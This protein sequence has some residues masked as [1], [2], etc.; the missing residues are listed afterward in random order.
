MVP[1]RSVCC[2]TS[3]FLTSAVPGIDLSVSNHLTPIGA[4]QSHGGTHSRQCV[5]TLNLYTASL[6]REHFAQESGSIRSPYSGRRR[7]SQHR[8]NYWIGADCS[9]AWTPINDCKI[10]LSHRQLLTWVACIQRGGYL[11]AT[12]TARLMLWECPC[13]SLTWPHRRATLC[14]LEI[15]TTCRLQFKAL[16]P[17]HTDGAALRSTNQ[18][19]RQTQTL[20]QNF[21]PS[22]TSEFH[23]I[24]GRLRTWWSR[25]WTTRDRVRCGLVRLRPVATSSPSRDTVDVGHCVSATPESSSPVISSSGLVVRWCLT[26]NSAC[27]TCCNESR[28]KLRPRTVPSAV[29]MRNSSLRTASPRIIPGVFQPDYCLIVWDRDSAAMRSVRHHPFDQCWAN[30]CGVPSLFWTLGPWWEQSYLGLRLACGEL[31]TALPLESSTTNCSM[32]L[33]IPWYF[34]K[35]LVGSLECNHDWFHGWAEDIASAS[36][37]CHTLRECLSAPEHLHSVGWYGY[38]EVPVMFGSRLEVAHVSIV[39]FQSCACGRL[40]VCGRGRSGKETK[41]RGRGGW[42]VRCQGH[43]KPIKRPSTFNPHNPKT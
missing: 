18:C 38:D 31:G 7:P 34:A 24:N 5:H 16:H 21:E 9:S 10:T 35:I 23:H 14:P 26:P 30:S 8:C 4:C 1:A 40:R 11:S 25:N 12:R 37:E 36:R 33:S 28:R 22:K 42:S 27:P 19:R 39:R 15:G 20:D 13:R 32:T 3:R 2:T 29:E 6:L 43:L 41:M 17:P